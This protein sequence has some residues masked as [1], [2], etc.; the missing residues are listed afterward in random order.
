[1]TKHTY[2]IQI[3][4]QSVK[5]YGSFHQALSHYFSEDSVIANIEKNTMGKSLNNVPQA[6]LDVQFDSNGMKCSAYLYRPATEATTP[7]IVMAHG[8][9]GTRRMRLTA[10]AERFVAEGYAC[11]VFDYRYFGDSEGQPR[12]LLDIKS[13]LEDWKAAIAYARSLD[14]IDP[15][16]VVIWGTSFG[17]GHVLATAADD[18]RLAAVISQCP[19]TDGFSSSMAMNPITTLKLTGLA[20][21][22]KI[23]SMFGAK[24]VMVPLAAPTGHTALMNAPDAYS[25]YLALMPSG[26]NIP[27]YVAARF[28]LDIIRYYPGRKTSRIQVPVLFCVCD[29]D[30]VAPSKKTLHHASHTP[31]HEIKHYADGHFEIYV[32]EAFER[33]VRDQIDFLKRIVPVK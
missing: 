7:I 14:K 11:L 25:G 15:N 12:Q 22:D 13:Q 33:V 9:G 1:M 19:F 21:K 27:N 17:G 2:S 28:V 32:G 30:S 6:P 23:G 24:P 18:N 26:S 29:T 10:F 16:R 31:N 5:Q 8:L 4:A 20:L 3:L